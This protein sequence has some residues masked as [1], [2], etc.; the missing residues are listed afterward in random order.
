MFRINKDIDE[1]VEELNK[2][3]SSKFKIDYDNDN[4]DTIMIKV[5]RMQG[6]QSL[7]PIIKNILTNKQNE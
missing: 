1:I 5:L 3:I 2:I 6:A 4:Q 7:V